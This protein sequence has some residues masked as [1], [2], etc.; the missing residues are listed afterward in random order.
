MQEDAPIPCDILQKHNKIQQ[1]DNK[2][3]RR[4]WLIE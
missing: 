2:N 4:F 3:N 1:I